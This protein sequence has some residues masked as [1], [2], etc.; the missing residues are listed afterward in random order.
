MN[1]LRQVKGA[2]KRKYMDSNVTSACELDANIN[3]NM[4]TGDIS[5]SRVLFDRK[6]CTRV[7]EKHKLMAT[8]TAIIYSF[9]T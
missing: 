6:A 9:L 4:Q 2:I 5:M 8:R 1:L 7:K 3:H